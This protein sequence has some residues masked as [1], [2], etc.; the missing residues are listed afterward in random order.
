MLVKE[1]LA[2]SADGEFTKKAVAMC[3]NGI[4]LVEDAAKEVKA[5]LEYP[6]KENLKDDKMKKVIEDD[7]GEIADA[8]IAGFE[9][10]ELQS[11]IEKNEFKGFVNA[12][13]KE[14][15][16]KGKRLFMPFRIALT[17]RMQGPEVGDVLGLIATEG[18]PE[19]AVSL[20]DR[21]AALK[22]ESAAWAK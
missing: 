15:G 13:G 4:E 6:L 20:D 9:S 2:A 3:A 5:I 8:I 22:A 1:G 10:G 16:R 12:T 21:V 18:T 17:G 19:S 14:L 11:A 7:F